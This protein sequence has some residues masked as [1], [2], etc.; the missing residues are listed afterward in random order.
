MTVYS[1]DA[2][3]L[4]LLTALFYLKIPFSTT[5]LRP[6]EEKLSIRDSYQRLGDQRTEA[7]IG[8]YAFKGTD[9]TGGFVSKALKSYFKAF[10]AADNDILDAF[11]DYSD[12]VKLCQ[13]EFSDKWKGMFAFYTDLPIANLKH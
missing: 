11:S 4:V 5:V 13:K 3:V 6:N 12:V 2:D 8:W 10:L 7:L 9:N 1:L